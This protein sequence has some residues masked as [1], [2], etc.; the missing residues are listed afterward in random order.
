MEF[1]YLKNCIGSG[2]RASRDSDLLNRLC[3]DQSKSSKSL[4]RNVSNSH[5]NEEHARNPNELDHFLKEE[6]RV[7][8]EIKTRLSKSNKHLKFITAFVL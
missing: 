5:I 4:S 2:S 3:E 6:G 7:A 1:G 8:C